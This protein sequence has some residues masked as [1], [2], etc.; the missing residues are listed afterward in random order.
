[1]S[2]IYF[3]SSYNSTN[4]RVYGL[5]QRILGAFLG[6]F[7]TWMPGL[8]IKVV[9]RFFMDTGSYA[10]NAQESACLQNGRPFQ[11]EVHGK[12]ISAWKW[13]QG[14]GVLMVHGWG[15]RGAQFHKFVDPLVQAGYT[16]IVFDG[17]GHGSSGGRTANYFVFTDT[18][19]AF[20]SPEL[21]LN[22][23]GIIG[24]SFGAGAIINSLDKNQSSLNT[25]CIAP[26]LRLRE[27]MLH[28]FERL[29][30][31]QKIFNAM[32]GS[33]EMRYGYSLVKDN[34]HRLIGRISAPILII[35][36]AGDR[37][38]AYADSRETAIAYDH[39]AL[40]TTRGLGHRRILSDARVI[41]AAL[42][43]IGPPSNKDITP[44]QGEV[45]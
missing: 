31:P 12:M 19:R 32:I 4:V 3:N 29:G 44:Y 11:V 7:Q 36:D 17:P 13:G 37:T 21:G 20:L 9:K 18:V 25:V 6:F 8:T 28:T 27:L 24:H 26:M 23:Q 10:L 34:P 15:G 2:E 14:P 33:Y 5:R 1:M 43:H 39:I 22:I 16:A 30:V 42:I 41:D 45:A 40:F 38:A 35:H